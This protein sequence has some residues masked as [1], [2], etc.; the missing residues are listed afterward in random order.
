MKIEMTEQKVSEIAEILETPM[1]CY[2]NLKTG[3]V[4]EIPSTEVLMYAEEELWDEVLIAFADV[5]EDCLKF[6]KVTQE[7]SLQIMLDFT[8][9][10]EDTNFHSKL[11]SALEQ[12][13]PLKHFKKLIDHSEY[14]DDWHEFWKQA[15]IKAVR[16]QIRAYEEKL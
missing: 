15:E 9:T 13:K 16:E 14:R 5:C 2:Y 6:E 8:K 7:K 4:I 3:D 1:D 10:I 12:S 11:M